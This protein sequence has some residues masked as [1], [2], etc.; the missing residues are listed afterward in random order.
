M[1]SERRDFKKNISDLRYEQN[2]L[3][4][5]Y[6]N[7]RHKNRYGRTLADPVSYDKETKN[8]VFNRILQD[9]KNSLKSDKTE[10]TETEIAE[11]EK[12]VAPTIFSYYNEIRSGALPFSVTILY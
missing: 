5:A 8:R 1:K 2:D 6:I 12:R 11:Y 10:L 7:Y 3:N 4:G 9:M